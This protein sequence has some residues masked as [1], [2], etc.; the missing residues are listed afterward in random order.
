VHPIVGIELDQIEI[1]VHGA[2]GI[3]EDGAQIIH[4]QEQRRTGIE[5]EPLRLPDAAAASRVQVAL[6]HRDPI[7]P[8]AQPHGGGEPPE[9]GAD[10][11]NVSRAPEF[12]T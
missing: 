9:S 10:H 8:A 1:V 12:V 3:L 11:E 2:A 7:S 5:A 6:H 4:H